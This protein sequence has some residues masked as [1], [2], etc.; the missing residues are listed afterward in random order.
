MGHIS[1]DQKE[2]LGTAFNNTI[3]VLRKDMRMAMFKEHGNLWDQECRDALSDAQRH[4]WDQQIAGGVSPEG[5]IDF[6]NIGTISVKNKPA[7]KHKF[8]RQYNSAISWFNELNEVRRKWAH[9]HPIE[10]DDWTFSIGT[11]LKI[12]KALNSQALEEDLR[13]LQAPVSAPADVASPAQ[14]SSPASAEMGP[15]YTGSLP[16]WFDVVT[17]HE[18]IRTGSLDESVFAANLNQVHLREG[19]EVYSN[20]ELF[21]KKTFF[22]GGLLSLAERVVKSLNGEQQGENRVL[23]LQT[24]FG[25]GKTHA[26]IS[27]Y[28]V[29]TLGNKCNTTDGLQDL[30][31]KTG[32]VTFSNA[33]IAVF[34]NATNDPVQGREVEPGLRVKTI[35]GEIAYQLGGR[36]A[37]ERIRENDEKQTAPKG[38]L[39]DILESCGPALILIDELADYCISAS[40]VRVGDSNLSDQTISFVQELTEAIPSTD[41]VVLV[42]TLPASVAE[43][44]NSEKGGQILTSL[45]QR[46]VRLGQDTKPVAEDEI[47]EVIR[48]RLFED[49]G[50]EEQRKQVI[51]RYAQHYT[52]LAFNHEVPETATKQSY[53]T[54]MEKSYPFHPELIDVFRIRWASNHH[55]QRTRG[56]LRML[57]SVVADQWKRRAHLQ[58]NRAMIHMSDLRLANLHPITAQVRMLNGDGYAA[59]M[60]ADVAGGSS[61]AHR[62]DDETPALG[63]HAITK[64]LAAAVLLGSFGADGAN[65]G[66]SLKDLKLAVTRPDTFNHNQVNT[67]MDRLEQRAHY[68]H[69]TSSAS[70]KRYWFGT[71]ANLNILVSEAQANVSS[72]NV[73]AD[74]LR[75]LKKVDPS[76]T[77]FPRCIVGIQDATLVPEVKERTLMILGPEHVG[78]LAAPSKKTTD[79]IKTVATSRGDQQRVY[80]NTLVYLSANEQGFAQLSAKTK[81]FLACETLL[82]DMTNLEPD[83]RRDLEK[84]RKTA[85]D[86][87]MKSLASTYT[88]VSRYS[89]KD[90]LRTLTI[91]DIK[92][93]LTSQIN[94]SLPELLRE[95]EWLLSGVGMNMLRTQGLVPESGS[96]MSVKAICDAFL[97]YDDKPQ[98][99]NQA[100]VLNSLKKY[101]DAGQL[102]IAS[103]TPPDEWGRVYFKEAVPH[104]DGNSD[105]WFL[106]DPADVPTPEAATPGGAAPVD[107]PIPSAP[108]DG[109]SPEAPTGGESGTVEVEKVDHIEVSGSVP[110]RQFNQ[111]FQSFILPMSHKGA[112]PLVEVNIKAD[113][114]SASGLQKNDPMYKA[115]VEAARQMGI[116]WTEE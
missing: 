49:L 91:Q 57:G 78:A 111:L 83:Q 99:E 109:G 1:D 30:V 98:V 87:V 18:D 16:F 74:I 44:A 50:S 108:L 106:L 40:A 62:I 101:C 102:A 22:T 110:F 70:D 100:S 63:H 103:G 43:V 42:A 39:S 69:F 14:A 38:I 94:I 17:P 24:G 96:P 21:F 25:G 114:S 52:D 89:A 35:W 66:M 9:H 19:R 4:T 86:E 71:K 68:L 105:D 11:M 116:Q 115:M 29:V 27:L 12:A 92:S 23:S 2:K 64:G 75:R 97:Q 61:N 8:G 10:E 67:A 47:F 37:Y 45:E 32:Q 113:F 36:E 7:L 90:G 41:R 53:R 51:D 80:R 3:E 107:A 93:N 65:R 5:C 31:N 13:L 60:D 82:S 20:A 76:V 58:G 48:R 104:L 72:A 54:Q 55:F 84:R 88:L 28:H 46:F 34:T 26:L 6:G 77:S 59:V 95:E 56:V 85:E 73:H 15:T 81:E 112:Q 33:N 79:F